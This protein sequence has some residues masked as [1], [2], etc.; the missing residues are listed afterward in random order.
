MHRALWCLEHL[1]SGYH[2]AV[3][4]PDDVAVCGFRVTAGAAFEVENALPLPDVG[5]WLGVVRAHVAS[6]SDDVD[7]AD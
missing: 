3:D 4:L 2:A 1:F 7:A 6:D 5:Q